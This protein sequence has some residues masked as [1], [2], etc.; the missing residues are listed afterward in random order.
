MSNPF[1]FS[2]FVEKT[3]KTN[4]EEFTKINDKS[5]K[6]LRFSQL[7]TSLDKRM[8]RCQKHTAETIVFIS[9]AAV[10]CGAQTWN[11]IED[12]GK[13][14]ESFF[15]E[16][17]PGFNGVPS[18]D[19]IGRFFKALDPEKFEEKFRQWLM[20]IVG[21]YKGSLAIDGKTICGASESGKKGGLKLHMV[22]VYATQLGISLGQLKTE[23][24]S[25]EIDAIPKLI[26]SIDVKGNVITIDAMGCQRKIAKTI[27][28]RGGDYLLIV[29]DNQKSLKG[30]IASIMEGAIAKRRA[31]QYDTYQTREQGH[32]RIE[33]RQCHSFGEMLCLGKRREQWKG[34]RSI[35]Y[36]ENKRQVKGEKATVNKRY[37]IS[38]LDNDACKIL[39]NSRMHWQVENGL[40]WQ[41]DVNFNED[42]T[43]KKNVAAQNFS[44]LAK[45]ALAVLKKDTRK[46]PINRKIK[47]AGWDNNYLWEL[48][49]I[50]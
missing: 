15:R 30:E 33:T 14:K 35:G 42:Q 18:H 28:D 36:I 25:N 49:S 47:M 41:L 16:K 21:K 31:N 50:L 32:G 43:R 20:E 40:H 2:I 11:D 44:L 3:T 38:S 29:K 22:S 27:I 12:F 1:I 7:I 26:E 17:I 48:L 23:D 37:F 13:S 45:I 5:G 6:L 39:Y 46:A 19:T 10:I 9:M 8:E 34:I 4:M 24:K